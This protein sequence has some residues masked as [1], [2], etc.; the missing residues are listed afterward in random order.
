MRKD[1]EGSGFPVSAIFIVILAVALVGLLFAYMNVNGKAA[2]AEFDSKRASLLVDRLENQVNAFEAVLKD[3]ESR[4]EQ[5]VVNSATATVAEQAA[6]AVNEVINTRLA[7]F[8]T[9]EMVASD[10]T[11]ADHDTPVVVIRDHEL[12]QGILLL[13]IEG[14]R[15]TTTCCDKVTLDN[16]RVALSNC[17]DCQEVRAGFACQGVLCLS[18]ALRM[19]RS[20][21]MQAT[22]ATF[23]GLPAAT[24][25]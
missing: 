16:W 3:T 11:G 4:V 22:S 23:L 18:M 9:L 2:K 1:Y 6:E 12:L 17:L 5:N 15:A 24:N 8:A 21:R 10:L 14:S 20:L 25:R 7:S 19:I 13:G